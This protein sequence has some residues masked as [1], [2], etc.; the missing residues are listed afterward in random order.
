M[1][2][3]NGIISKVVAP[4]A[5]Q[6][7]AKDIKQRILSGV[8]PEGAT[9]PNEREISLRSGLSRTSVREA[10]RMLEAEGLVEIKTGR[11]GGSIVRRPGS[12]V[13]LNSLNL[14]IWGQNIST[15][16][17]LDTRSSIEPP[18]ASLAAMYRTKSDIELLE[19][20]GAEM[21]AAVED[22]G[23][24]LELNRAWHLQVVKASNNSLL[25]HFYS[26]IIEEI[27]RLTGVEGFTSPA[28]RL[29]VLHIH[30]RVLSAI[31]EGDR[32]AAQRR[33]RRHIDGYVSRYEEWESDKVRQSKAS[34]GPS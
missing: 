20:I 27:Y 7:L 24:F 18:A 8:I 11:N 34:S 28:L 12:E 17:L 10:I 33:M 30:D 32:E 31:R 29:D 25:I 26:A 19:R 5:F 15:R 23:A 22:T 21:S 2:E 4:N 13:L 9:L 3:G 6:V 16:E 14:F 1:E